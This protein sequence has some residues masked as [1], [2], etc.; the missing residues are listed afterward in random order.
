M[1][2]TPLERSVEVFAVVQLGLAGLS[3]ILH[4]RVWAEF[5]IWLR[6]RGYAGV[7]VHGLMSLGF[8]AMILA[9]HQVWTGVPMVL[10][11]VG[12]LYLMKAV[13]CF[14]FPGVSLRSLE[15]VSVERSWV[16]AVPGAVFVGVAGVV[17]YGLM[18]GT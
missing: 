6:A 15:R 14:V 3:H 1:M 4:H 12:V 5:F 7:F 11:V 9:F 10:T 16:F 8:G 13:Q 18:I 17:G 2:L